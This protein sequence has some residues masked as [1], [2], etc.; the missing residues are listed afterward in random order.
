MLAALLTLGCGNPL[1]QND[2][3]ESDF[4]ITGR[5]TSDAIREASGLTRS[6]RTDRLWVIN[7][8]GSRPQL[9]AIGLDGSSHGSVTLQD[10]ANKDW[11][12]LASFK[13]DGRHWLIIAD[14]GDNYSRRDEVRLH[15]VEEPTDKQLH[16]GKVRP[17][18][19]IVFSYPNG[20][21]DAESIA[22]DEDKSRILI[23][24]KRDIPAVL[25]SVPLIPASAEP[26][27]ATRIG[28]VRGIPQP[29]AYDLKRA[30]PDLNWHWQPNAIDISSAGDAA[31]VLTYRATYYFQRQPGQT[32]LETLNSKP[33]VFALG[34]FSEAES[35]VFSSDGK[36]AYATT[37]SRNAP[38][39]RVELLRHK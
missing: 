27:T 3:A 30:I 8:S 35:V 6:S 4:E 33:E 31:L 26:I 7:D 24:T 21:R 28:E 39:L 22:V 25:Y 18:H 11:E 14:I 17:S 32:W 1:N 10:V 9:H 38:M 5:I 37:E 20:P 19:T 34:E 12:D 16:A 15:I 2:A 23:L 36:H 13:S 29:T